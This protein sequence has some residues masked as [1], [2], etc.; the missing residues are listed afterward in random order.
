MR[1]SR[2]P[3]PITDSGVALLVGVCLAIALVGAVRAADLDPGPGTLGQPVVLFSPAPPDA[4]TSKPV[5]G[6]AAAPV[7]RQ[8]ATPVHAAP[9]QAKPL[10]PPAPPPVKLGPPPD[11]RP[12]LSLETD[13]RPL[14]PAKATPPASDA[15]PTPVKPPAS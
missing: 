7:K 13:L 2:I 11:S 14:G 1:G 6:L 12:A 9:I 4:I 5:R 3:N 10:I 15:A 8:A